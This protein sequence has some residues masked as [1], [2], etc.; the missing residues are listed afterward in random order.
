M[1]DDLVGK[2]LSH[3]RVLSKAGA[4]GMGVVYRAFDERL[5]RTVALKTLPPGIV[6]NDATRRRVR[7]E[8]LALS[9]LSHPGIEV[10][11]DFDAHD[12]I[13]FLVMEFLEGRTLADVVADGPLEP[14]EVASLGGQIAEALHAAHQKRVI[15]RDLKPSNILVTPEGRAKLIDF[16]IAKNVAPGDAGATS[17]TRTDTATETGHGPKGTLPYMAPEQIRA[18]PVDPRTD[19]HALGITLYEMATGARPFRAPTETALI[20][21]IC[22]EPPVSPRSLSPK[23]NPRFEDVI[24]KCLEKDPGRRYQ[25]AIEVKVDLE[26]AMT[27]TGVVAKPPARRLPR[28]AIRAAV[29]LSLAAIA[30]APFWAPRLAEW[31]EARG[32]SGITSEGQQVTFSGQVRTMALAPDGKTMA[33]SMSESPGQSVLQTVMVQDVGTG[34]PHEVFRGRDINCM[35]WSPDG[36]TLACS[37]VTDD[38]GEAIYLIPRFGG[39]ATVVSAK[40]AGFTWSPDGRRFATWRAAEK[41]VALV[42]IATGSRTVVPLRASILW[43]NGLDWSPD[44]AWFTLTSVDDRQNHTLW[45]LRSDGRGMQAVLR[46]SVEIRSPRWAPNS[47]AIFYLRGAEPVSDLWRQNVHRRTGKADGRPRAIL[48]GRGF[49]KEF[50]LSRDGSRLLYPALRSRSNLW[51]LEIHRSGAGAA[52]PSTRLTTGT[53]QD[54][55]P[56]VDPRGDRVAFTRR[57]GTRAHLYVLD[58]KRGSTRRLTFLPSVNT[59]PVWSPEGDRIAFNSTEG[60]KGNRAWVVAASGGTP[61]LLAKTLLTPDIWS[62]AWAPG[63]RIA[64]IRPGNRE[65]ATLD[66]STGDE[67]AIVRESEAGFCFTPAYSPDGSSL[68]F[69]W[70]RKSGPEVW[71]VDL[72]SKAKAVVNQGSYAMVVGWSADSR[73]IYYLDVGGEPARLFRLP[74]H[75]GKAE[76]VGEIAAPGLPIGFS[77]TPDG[78]RAV[79]ACVERESDLWL[80]DSFRGS[81]S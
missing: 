25:T 60:G 9:K 20:E 52:L 21:A 72:A 57:E 4:G 62:M 80:I 26:R 75:G 2:T 67:E 16:G 18:K 44:G 29:V 77:L 45:V 59:Q 11:Y 7:D 50:S 10:V 38:H 35:R 71:R 23:L 17:T 28:V 41:T 37:A 46:D 79:A 73:W 6:A 70:N 58:M 49:T 78:K 31:W 3:Y 8:A 42:E 43:V 24:L 81:G 15:H 74:S 39:D 51:L 61:L 48:G 63:R 68:A 47:D 22:H 69:F 65:L 56:S 12:G 5:R 14:G 40:A 36:T 27:G 54:E 30:S 13:D 64:F 33:Y 1:T 66:P 32:W 55:D 19:V 34:A 53:F 76:L